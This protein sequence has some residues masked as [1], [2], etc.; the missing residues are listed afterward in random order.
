MRKWSDWPTSPDR[1]GERI[2]GVKTKM[3]K[4][5]DL[6]VKR[7]KPIPPTPLIKGGF[8]SL[9]SSGE[10][11]LLFL[12]PLIKG[13]KNGSSQK[14]PFDKGE[15]T[16]SPKCPPSTR[17]KERRLRNAPLRQG[18]IKGGL[19]EGTVIYSTLH[20]MITHIR[21]ASMEFG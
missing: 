11:M 6:S 19:Y 20:G 12:P 7:G 13:G 2:T 1:I 16:A 10:G 21:N 14:P 18:G 4:D 5:G 8:R 15:R 9:R 17:G 3:R